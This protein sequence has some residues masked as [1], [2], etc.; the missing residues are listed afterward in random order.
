MNLKTRRRINELEKTLYNALESMYV[1]D[2]DDED[3]FVAGVEYT[4]RALWE[5]GDD[6]IIPKVKWGDVVEL[7]NDYFDE[8]IRN[9]YKNY[10]EECEK[11]DELTEYPNFVYEST[12]DLSNKI[13]RRISMS[14]ELWKDLFD[15][16]DVM[17]FINFSGWFEDVM[18]SLAYVDNFQD[19]SYTELNQIIK[20]FENDP[21]VI[22]M[23]QDYYLKK[24]SHDNIPYAVFEITKPLAHMPM[25]YYY[26]EAPLWKTQESIIFIKK[27]VSGSKSISTNNIKVLKIFPEGDTKE[28][29]DYL[30]ELRSKV[31]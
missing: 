10:V 4:L 29:K 19:F 21:K 1:C 30:E 2:Y 27:G 18:N 9:Y 3:H 14:D 25:K 22:R 15:S 28:L 7:L 31:I 24:L 26:Q 20:Y 13:K 5:I 16:A 12:E 23:A 11:S 17:D 6:D 8:L